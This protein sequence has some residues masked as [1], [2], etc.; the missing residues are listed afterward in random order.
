[1]GTADVPRPGREVRGS[2]TGRPIMAALDLLGRRWA[3]RVLWE[4]RAGPLGFRELRVR[5]DEMSSSVLSV[6]LAELTA[7]GL[8]VKDDDR[9]ALSA[10]GERL[11]VAIEPLTAWADEWSRALR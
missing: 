6:R 4:L 1:M 7:A 5:C 8:V 3:M 9:Y 11:A 2:R 10:L